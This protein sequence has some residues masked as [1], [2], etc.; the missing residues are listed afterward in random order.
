M[1]YGDRI[2]MFRERNKMFQS[3]LGKALGVSAQAVSKWELNKAEP[4]S[5]S[6]TKMCELFDTDANELMGIKP[7]S[8]TSDTDDE[9]WQLREQLR[10]DPERRTLFDAVK[11]VKKED[12]MTA[13]RIIDA[14]KDDDNYD[15]V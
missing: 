13:V 14:L 10:R 9:I 6:I 11:S 12:I 1:A 3:D 15:P 8:A 5:E 2:R 4:D 7:I